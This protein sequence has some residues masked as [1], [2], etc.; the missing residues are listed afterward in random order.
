MAGK[1]A[2]SFKWVC[3]NKCGASIIA[4]RPCDVCEVNRKLRAMEE[5]KKDKKDKK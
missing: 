3:C 2:R 4:N 1:Q 5:A